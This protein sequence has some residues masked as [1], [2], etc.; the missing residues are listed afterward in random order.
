MLGYQIFVEIQEEK[1]M[2]ERII[3]FIILLIIVYTLTFTL[4]REIDGEWI[5]AIIVGLIT[6]IVVFIT[7]RVANRRK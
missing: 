4:F 1:K 5:K 6:G 7:E 2:K 3:G